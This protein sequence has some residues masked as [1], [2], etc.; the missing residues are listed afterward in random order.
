MPNEDI[1]FLSSAWAISGEI[2]KINWN[3]IIN[4]VNQI[5]I[6][7]D[8][9]KFITNGSSL[10]I[11]QNGKYRGYIISNKHKYRAKGSSYDTYVLIS[12][13]GK[14]IKEIGLEI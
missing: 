1:Y 2:Y 3:K 8:D 7:I 14:E 9:I 11:I 4:V 5:P 13:L 12:P 10:Y 6:T